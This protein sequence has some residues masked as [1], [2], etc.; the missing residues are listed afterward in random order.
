[1]ETV[2]LNIND[3]Q[4]TAKKGITVLEAAQ[5]A[6]IYI[7]RLCFHSGLPYE[8]RSEAI[9]TVYQGNRAVKGD[10]P[11]RVFKGCRLC[12]INVEGQE[13]PVCSCELVVSTGMVVHTD[14]AE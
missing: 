7:P 3:E 6:G 12:V 11:G 10:E 14:T 9:N 4:V 13:E 1:M 2:T 8:H 5:E